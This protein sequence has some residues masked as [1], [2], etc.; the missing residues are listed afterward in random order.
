MTTMTAVLPFFLIDLLPHNTVLLASAAQTVIASIDTGKVLYTVSHEQP[1]L[2]PRI[3]AIVPLSTSQGSSSSH[4]ESIVDCLLALLGDDKELHVYKV[5]GLST[6]NVNLEKTWSSPLPKRGVKMVWEEDSNELEKRLIVGDRHG[7]VRSFSISIKNTES[8]E[9][10]AKRR[11]MT[12]IEAKAQDDEEEDFDSSHPPH[13]GH[14]SMLTDFVLTSFT[15]SS[16]QSPPMYIITCD[17]DEHIRI[18]RWGKRRAGHLALRYLLGSREAV[19]GLCVIDNELIGVLQQK[20][21]T[22]AAKEIVKCPLLVSTESS[23][24]R[25]WSL[26]KDDEASSRQDCQMVIDLKDI[27]SPYLK[28]DSQRERMRERSF[29]KGKV[30]SKKNPKMLEESLEA[31]DSEKTNGAIIMTNLSAMHID[32]E[33][34]VSFIVDGASALFTVPLSRL[35]SS[36]TESAASHIQVLDMILPIVDQAYQTEGDEKKIWMTCDVRPDVAKSNSNRRGLRMIRWN[37]VQQC[38]E[39]EDGKANQLIENQSQLESMSTPEVAN[40]LLLYDAMTLYIK[41][42]FERTVLVEQSVAPNG[43]VRGGLANFE[44]S[45]KVKGDLGPANK[46]NSERETGKKVKAREEMLKRIEQA[47]GGSGEQ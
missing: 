38:W 29:G 22:E 10:E 32:G 44:R 16:T 35:L 9:R 23:R 13:L 24:L 30:D 25:I 20:V 26:H 41:Q 42:E 2:A 34:Y 4:G 12:T 8:D 6:H 37:R 11:R 21:K 5:S 43:L 47:L 1:I 46:G 31:V 18:S 19:G 17:R 45:T 15:S 28:V 7:D 40:S 36:A 39:E 27:V 33:V 3:S 14:V